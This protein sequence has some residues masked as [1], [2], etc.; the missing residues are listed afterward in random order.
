[1]FQKEK[2]EGGIANFRSALQELENHVLFLR[3]QLQEAADERTTLLHVQRQA[4]TEMNVLTEEKEAANNKA[5]Q[6]ERELSLCK[7]QLK[8]CFHIANLPSL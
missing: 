8:A 7:T 5:G 2:I 3:K 6:I 1:M 4:K